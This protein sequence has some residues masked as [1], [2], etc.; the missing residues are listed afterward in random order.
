VIAHE[1]ISLPVDVASGRAVI[2]LVP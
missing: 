2:D 1:H